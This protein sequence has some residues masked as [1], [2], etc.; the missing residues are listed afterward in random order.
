MSV[1]EVNLIE[2]SNPIYVDFPLRGE[3]FTPNTPAKRI[4]SHGMDA[5]RQCLSI[6]LLFSNLFGIWVE[7]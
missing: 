2:L 1:L 6:I 4:P 5:L 3:W 7:L